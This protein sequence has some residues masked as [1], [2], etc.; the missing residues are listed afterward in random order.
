MWLEWEPDPEDPYAEASAPLLWCYGWTMAKDQLATA[1][2]RFGFADD[3]G[4]GWRL[5]DDLDLRHTYICT[6]DGSGDERTFY[7]CLPSESSDPRP[8]TFAT[9]PRD[10]SGT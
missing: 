6:E 1:L 3:L 7:E 5:A 4:A 10:E 2:F 9:R 8:V